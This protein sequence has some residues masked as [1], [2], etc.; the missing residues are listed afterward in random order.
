MVDSKEFPIPAS[1]ILSNLVELLR[2]QNDKEMVKLLVRASCRI[3]YKPFESFG[4]FVDGW[5]VFIEV[6]IEEYAFIEDKVEN[7]KIKLSQKVK[8]LIPP[9]NGNSI[10]EFYLKPQ[11]IGDRGQ[12]SQGAKLD[13]THIWDLGCLKLFLSHVSA[14]KKKV[15]ELKNQL[16]EFNISAFVAHEDIEPSRKWQKEIELAL[17]TMDVFVPLLTEDFH[18]SSW[19]DQEVGIAIGLGT[20]II[21]IRLG[22]DPYGF[23]G[24]NQGLAGN[25][26]KPR[27]LASDIVEVLLSNLRLGPLMRETFVGALEESENFITSRQFAERLSEI[28]GFTDNQIKRLQAALR[29]NDQVYNAFNVPDWINGIVKRHNRAKK[30]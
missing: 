26:N 25:L 24:E 16:R 21:P 20:V 11:L 27:E 1:T 17:N 6:P 23:I 15:V 7:I 13:S 9:E 22:R 29:N 3:E 12:I 18:E 5:I 4:D 28:D 2:H 10:N 8:S 30:K 14:H 19:T